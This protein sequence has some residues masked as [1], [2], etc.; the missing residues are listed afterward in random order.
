MSP[1]VVAVW[2]SNGYLGSRFVEMLSS[3]TTVERIDRRQLPREAAICIDSSFPVHYKS[4]S[5]AATYLRT[6]EARCRWAADTGRTYLY[7]ASTSSLAP[8]TSVYGRVKRSAE[9]TALG[10]GHQLVRVGLVVSQSPGGRYDQLARIVRALPIV[11]IPS[12]TEFHLYVTDLADLLT[13][14]DAQIPREGQATRD[15]LVPGTRPSTLAEL[16]GDLVEPRQ[17]VVPLGPR[18]SALAAR[19][20]RSLHVGSL[21]SLASIA[22]A[23]QQRPES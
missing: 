6:V 3:R 21:D 4:S 12:T 22:G 20:A 8:V 10:H 17:R 18:V 7:I 1:P 15:L 13:C 11:P 5:V 19:V 14:I 9:E 23:R 16:L 2:G